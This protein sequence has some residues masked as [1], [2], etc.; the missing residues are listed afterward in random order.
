M[1]LAMNLSRTAPDAEDAIKATA[2]V[3]VTHEVLE[4]GVHRSDANADIA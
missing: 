4:E 1:L 2:T 3:P